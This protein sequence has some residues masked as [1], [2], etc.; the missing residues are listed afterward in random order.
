MNETLQNLKDRGFLS[1]CTDIDALSKKMDE[2]AVTFYEGCDPTGSSLHIGHMVPYFA[3]KHLCEAGHRGIALIG[4]G[5][6]R[7]GD[8]SGKT[9]MRKIISYEQIDSNFESIKKQLDGF[10]HFDGKNIITVNNKDWLSDLNYIDFLREIGSCFSVNKMLTFEAYKQRLEK[11]LSFIEFN[12]QLLQAFDYLNLHTKY[13]ASLQIGGDDQ[14]GNITAGVDLIR[15]KLGGT[16]KLNAEHEVFGLTFPLIMTS[17]GRKMGKTEKGAI[18]L[19]TSITSP[20][21]FFQ[22][23]RNCT[24]ADV[25][26][27]FKLFTFLPLAEIDSICSG[28]INAA[29]ERLAYEVTLVIHGK[30]EAEKAL[31]GAKA[32]FGGDGDKSMMPTVKIERALIENGIGVIDLFDAA[33]IGGSKSEIRRLIQ[34]GGAYINSAAVTD[35]K[36]ILTLNDADDSGEFI[37]RAGKKKIVRVIC[38]R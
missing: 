31:S 24:D 34:Q 1:Q 28:N 5:T 37:L 13:G 12:Y 30:D 9:E 38:E 23:W 27:F 7:I 19:D 36:A 22:Y 6:A 25:G 20:Y 21:D 8:P 16:T 35:V 3:F 29:K 2:G 11:G 26:R 4:G 33:K 15:R 18:F 14:W 32:A 17:D 10:L